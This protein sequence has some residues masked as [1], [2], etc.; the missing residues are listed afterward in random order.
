MGKPSTGDG[1]NSTGPKLSLRDIIFR[2]ST[3]DNAG[4]ASDVQQ[5]TTSRFQAENGIKPSQQRKG[6]LR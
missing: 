5:A 3:A 2:R 4:L 1:K 6:W